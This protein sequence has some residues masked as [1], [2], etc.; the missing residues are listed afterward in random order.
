MLF[1]SDSNVLG[2]G[3]AILLRGG[4]AFRGTWVRGSAGEPTRFLD[5]AGE[6]MRFAQGQ[7]WIELVPRGR[8]ATIG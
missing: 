8:P 4:R 2:E 6:P 7:T 5:A 1:R 3:E